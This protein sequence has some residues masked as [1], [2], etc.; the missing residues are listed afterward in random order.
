[1]KIYV[2]VVVLYFSSL[3]FMAHESNRLPVFLYILLSTTPPR[4][5]VACIVKYYEEPLS[6]QVTFY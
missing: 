5:V 4:L 2:F 1:M 6:I 3:R